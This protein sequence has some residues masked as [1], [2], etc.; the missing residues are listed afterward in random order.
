MKMSN[1]QM[2][3]DRIKKL[4]YEVEENLNNKKLTPVIDISVIQNFLPKDKD[5]EHVGTLGLKIRFHLKESKKIVLRLEFE[6][7]AGFFGNPQIKEKDFKEL[8]IKSGIISLLQISRAKIIAI[9]SN[10]G[11][12]S[13]IYLPMMNVKEIIEKELEKLNL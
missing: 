13:P 11:F 4:N 10:F 3:Y 2:R 7:E 5:K 12:I 1:I 9:T 6:I 8:V